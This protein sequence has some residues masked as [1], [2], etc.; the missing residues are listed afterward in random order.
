MK[1]LQKL[2]LALCCYG[3]LAWAD[4]NDTQASLPLWEAGMFAATFNG[5]DYPAANTRQ[6]NFIAAPYFIYRGEI[7]RIGD[8]SALRAVAVDTERWEVDL[9]LDAAFNSDS[10]GDS[11]RQGMPD[12]DYVF[13]IGPQI[14]YRLKDYN[15]DQG[16]KGKLTL[17]LQAR[18]AF[19]TD[20]SGLTHRG[21]VFHP[22]IS[23]QH[24]NFHFPNDRLTLEIAPIW[25]TEKLQDYFYEVANDYATA[26]RPTYDAKGGYL[27]TEVGVSYGL[28]YDQNIRLFFGVNLRFLHGAKNQQSPLFYESN[29]YSLGVGLL[30]RFY[31]SEQRVSYMS[32]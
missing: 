12:L 2:M 31:Q 20:F 5:P 21:Y 8:G 25:S 3:H 22:E 19:S 26:Q 1:F 7:F 14:K 15:F 30:W 28:D 16:G 27:G 13:E 17:K 18:A 32:Q 9:S 4:T 23:Y 24:T 6:T 11:A 29:T 10:D